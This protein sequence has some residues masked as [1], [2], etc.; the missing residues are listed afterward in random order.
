[1][2]QWEWPHASSGHT[3]LVQ[4]GTLR[5]PTPWESLC[6]RRKEKQPLNPCLRASGLGEFPVPRSLVT[7]V[8]QCSWESFC[9]FEPWGFESKRKLVRPWGRGFAALFLLSILVNGKRHQDF[10][11]FVSSKFHIRTSLYRC[12]WYL[13]FLFACLKRW[14]DLNFF[15]FVSQ[16]ISHTFHFIP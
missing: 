6:D 8:T 9:S 3:V 1:M 13:V 16:S 7:T 15:Q 14:S 11:M 2:V 10:Q 4:V 5:D 12:F